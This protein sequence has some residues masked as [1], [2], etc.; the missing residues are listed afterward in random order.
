MHQAVFG[1]VVP[2]SS[3][4]SRVIIGSPLYLQLLEFVGANALLLHLVNHGVES[5]EC[6]FTGMLRLVH[7][8]AGHLRWSVIT[9][10]I[11]DAAVGFHGDLFFQNQFAVKS[12]CSSAV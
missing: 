10:K 3:F 8:S 11:V 9:E 2:A 6:G 12:P 1:H 5:G 4:E 7:N